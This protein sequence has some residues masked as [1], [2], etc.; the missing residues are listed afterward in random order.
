ML[1]SIFVNSPGESSALHARTCK[2]GEHEKC[3]LF[4]WSALHQPGQRG[5]AEYYP[6]RANG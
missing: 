1:V 6:I 2:T 3:T 5:L 4:S